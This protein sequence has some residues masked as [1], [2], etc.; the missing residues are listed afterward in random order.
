MKKLTLLFAVLLVS[1]AYAATL[2]ILTLDEMTGISSAVVQGRIV[3]SRSDWI[4]GKSSLIVTY[5]TVQADSYMKGNLGRTFQLTEPGGNV[6]IISASVAGAPSFQVGEQVVLFVQTNGSR[7]LHQAIGFEQGVFRVRRD[8]VS[9]ALTVNHSQPLTKGGQIVASD[10]NPSLVTG[11][12]T[13]RDLQQFLS[14]VGDSVR[15]VAASKKGV[16]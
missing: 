15:R 12:R 1:T 3:A 6:G 9:G 8:S 10:E 11:A 4:N 7:N 13:A 2:Q 16:Q 14:Q 5:Y